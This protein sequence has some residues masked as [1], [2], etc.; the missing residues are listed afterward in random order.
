MN[1]STQFYVLPFHCLFN[2]NVDLCIFPFI[3]MASAS[4]KNEIDQQDVDVAEGIY[5][6]WPYEWKINRKKNQCFLVRKRWRVQE[7]YGLANQMQDDECKKLFVFNCL[8]IISLR[9]KSPNPYF[10]KFWSTA[11]FLSF[12]RVMVEK[13]NFAQNTT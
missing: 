6:I 8:N 13:Q 1:W 3:G 11:Y 9:K 2:L 4:N 12:V 7:D 5:Y 10:K